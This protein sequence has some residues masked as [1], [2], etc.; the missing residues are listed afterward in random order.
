LHNL[1]YKWP[2]TATETYRFHGQI[3][4]QKLIDST[5]PICLELFTFG[6]QLY[7]GRDLYCFCTSKIC[8]RN[9]SVIHIIFGGIQSCRCF[10]YL[11]FKK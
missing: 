9:L 4:Q 7:Q 6:C 8:N 11:L 2:D 5:P 10:G 1:V 3:L